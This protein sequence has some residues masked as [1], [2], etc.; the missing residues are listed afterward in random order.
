MVV[1]GAYDGVLTDVLGGRAIAGLVRESTYLWAVAALARR[2]P[3]HLLGDASL[4]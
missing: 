2:P 4:Q 3:R 1:A